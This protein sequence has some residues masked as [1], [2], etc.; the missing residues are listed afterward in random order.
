MLA[1][2][3]VSLERGDLSKMAS[4]GA[5]QFLELI[6]KLAKL[7]DGSLVDLIRMILVETDYITYID[8]KKSSDTEN[9]IQDNVNELLSD[10]AE[11]DGRGLEGN[12][13]EV[14][15]E[16]VSLLSDTDALD[17]S[18][19]QVTLMT[20]HAAK[21]LEFKHVYIIALEENILPHIRSMDDPN[22]F[23]EE[24]R[25]LFVGITRAKETL[26]LSLTRKRGFNRMSVPSGFLMELPR[27]EMEISDM[28]DPFSVYDIDQ[29]S[30]SSFMDDF[31][32]DEFAD[33]ESK[34]ASRKKK[35]DQ[36]N[37]SIYL[38][39]EDDAV[40]DD[41]PDEGISHRK[42]KR[43]TKLNLA[44]LRP[45][46][47]IAPVATTAGAKVEHFLVGSE[48]HHP[49]YGNG[50][51]VSLDGRST[52]RMARVRF[53]SGKQNRSNWPLRL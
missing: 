47:E 30:S 26:Q 44:S 5:R 45:A 27:A 7:T 20:L 53:E 16:Q 14:F 40:I 24:R 49:K 2:L 3:R 21:G 29:D 35:Q 32:D 11:I 10:A 41:S 37:E 43:L 50:Y 31:F 1:A 23:E 9:S 19:G 39:T 33:N 18:A 28:S 17:P 12:Q 8:T 42:I 48:V 6:E 51:V 34:R 13:L 36:S 15:L 4:R 52:K 38:D 22:Q 46:A 25:L